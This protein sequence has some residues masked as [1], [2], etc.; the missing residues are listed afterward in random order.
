MRIVRQKQII[1]ESREML[2]LVLLR[3]G[4]EIMMSKV[5]VS[6]VDSL[7]RFS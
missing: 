7:S 2:S 4:L 1:A 6:T 5:A 3:T